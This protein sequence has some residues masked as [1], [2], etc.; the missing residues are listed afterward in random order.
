MVEAWLKKKKRTAGAMS[1]LWRT[2]DFRCKALADSFSVLPDV[3]WDAPAKL[4]VALWTPSDAALFPLKIVPQLL[5]AGFSLADERTG[6]WID[7]REVMSVQSGSSTYSVTGAAMRGQPD[8]AAE[9]IVLVDMPDHLLKQDVEA[10]VRHAMLTL[11]E[12]GVQGLEAFQRSQ[13]VLQDAARRYNAN[14]PVATPAYLRLRDILRRS[15]PEYVPLA[16][17]AALRDEGQHPGTMRDAY[18]ALVK[19]VSVHRGV[20]QLERTYTRVREALQDKHHL[21][22]VRRWRARALHRLMHQAQESRIY[23]VLKARSGHLLRDRHAIARELV[24]YWSTIMR[25]GQRSEEECYQWLEGRGLQAQWRTAVPLLWQGCSE[26][27]VYAALQQMDPS[28]SPGDDGIQAGVY[29]AFPEFFVRNMYRAYQEIEVEGLPD[30]WVTALVRSLPKDPGSAAVDRQ[31][32][33]ALQQARLKWLTGVLLLQLQDALFRLVPSQQKA[34]SRGRTMIDHLASVQ[35]TWHTGPGDEVAAWLVVDYGK[36]YDSVSHPMMAA[37]FRFICIPTPW[38]C[39]LLQILRGPFLFLVMG[40]VVREHSL[41]PASGMRQG[42]PLSPILF[43]LLTSVICFILRPYGV[44]V[45]LYSDDALVRLCRPS[46]GLEADLQSLLA[47]FAA[48]GE[49]TGLCLNLEKTRLLVQGLDSDRLAGIK[50][51]PHVRYLG[52]QV[53]HVSPAVAYERCVVLFESRCTRISRM[54]LSWAQKVVLVHTWCYPV[55]QVTAIAHYPPDLVVKRLRRALV[56]TFHAQNWKVPLNVLHLSPSEGGIGLWS[57]EVYLWTTHAA[58]FT[59]Y[60]QQPSRYGPGAYAVFSSWLERKGIVHTPS[61]LALLQMSPCCIRNAPWLA[62]SVKALS[63]LNAA[64]K[65]LGLEWQELAAAPPWNSRLLTVS[66]KSITCKF[67]IRKGI[68]RL[69]DVVDTSAWVAPVSRDW[70]G[71][72]KLQPHQY[73]ALLALVRRLIPAWEGHH[74]VQGVTPPLPMDQGL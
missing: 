73:Q 21:Q 47:E 35:Q 71:S 51:V 12:E 55:L 5:S 13:V 62:S 24:A 69:S 18:I 56:I 48:F 10:V 36:A 31:R 11:E 67:L 64:Q 57:P 19:V 15:S 70:Q 46:A 60:L 72:R 32:P 59:C 54:P 39:V 52:G 44:D 45:W 7:E 2:V 38:V 4:R 25:P 29:K 14:A 37:L 49:Y 16:G 20:E 53:G 30:E 65:G 68:L 41:T 43:S 17:F 42:D 9:P 3:Q 40:G 26:D 22:E 23:G 50:V 6:A 8:G 61:Q 34:Y 27:L 58:T 1:S 28:S 74:S 66:E 63:S 33:I